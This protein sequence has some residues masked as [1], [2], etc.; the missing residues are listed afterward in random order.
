MQREHFFIMAAG[1]RRQPEEKKNTT[2]IIEANIFSHWFIQMSLLANNISER[3]WSFSFAKLTALWHMTIPAAVFQSIDHPSSQTRGDFAVSLWWWNVYT[4]IL[5]SLWS[6]TD[7]M[8]CCFSA[9]TDLTCLSE[10]KKN[11][12]RVRLFLLLFFVAGFVVGD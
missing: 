6:A 1:K 7:K 5:L 11:S 8:C 3:H 12:K 9:E 10:G 4:A 2:S